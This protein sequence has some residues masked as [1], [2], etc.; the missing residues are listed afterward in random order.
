MNID[1][2]LRKAAYIGLAGAVL[3]AGSHLARGI[4]EHFEKIDHYKNM[5]YQE[6]IAEINTPQEAEW[7]VRNYIIPKEKKRLDS[8]KVLHENRKGDCAE[9]TVAVA[10]LLSDDGYP[11]T[12][13]EMIN[14][15]GTSGHGVFVYQQNDKYG[16]I[17]INGSDNIRPQYENIEDLVNRL[18]YD[19]FY[20]GEIG[21]GIIP[22]W[23]STDRN[24]V[25]TNEEISQLGLKDRTSSYTEIK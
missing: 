17:G 1:N 12:Y 21:W 14:S 15:S 4:S 16:S 18:G 22:D 24:L 10:A 6:V 7:Y 2:Y 25:F 8:F 19:K 20:F 5:P 3:W 11:P 23:I 9:A 13:L